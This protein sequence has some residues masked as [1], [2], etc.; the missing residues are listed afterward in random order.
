MVSDLMLSIT[1]WLTCQDQR[2]LYSI[3]VINFWNIDSI[4]VFLRLQPSLLSS[5]AAFLNLEVEEEVGIEES[6]A[7]QI[8]P[9]LFVHARC[10]AEVWICII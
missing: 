1:W 5:N 7:M 9:S 2:Y 4:T 3:L 8:H 6:N 10:L